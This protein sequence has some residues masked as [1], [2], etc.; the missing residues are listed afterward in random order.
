MKNARQQK[1]KIQNKNSYPI[2]RQGNGGHVDKNNE[3]ASVCL[4]VWH[5]CTELPSE[6]F[7][8]GAKRE[9]GV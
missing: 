6:L 7:A 5:I 4:F 2:R 9:Q 1:G 8:S 3:C